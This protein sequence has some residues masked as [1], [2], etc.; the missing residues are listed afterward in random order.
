M[1][2]GRQV[3]TFDPIAQPSGSFNNQ[4]PRGC[5]IIRIKNDSIVDLI[6]SINNFASL[7]TEVAP[8]A[9]V[10]IEGEVPYTQ[11]YWSTQYKLTTNVKT[12]AS[13]VTVIVYDPGET[14]PDIT[15]GLPRHFNPTNVG[16]ETGGGISMP[17]LAIASIAVFNP[18]GSGVNATF[19][20]CIYVG[21]NISPSQPNLSFVTS[22]PSLSTLTITND[23]LG[24]PASACHASSSGNTF[25]HGTGM[26]SYVCGGN[27]QEL[28]A[29]PRQIVAPPGFGLAVNVG[30]NVSTTQTIS[31]DFYWTETPI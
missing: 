25:N 28:I 2:R 30:S 23:T 1:A 11:I 15:A 26:T 12:I 16:F 29:F 31:V 20:S 27:A 17:A 10:D 5:G 8:G 19:I 21:L 18:P 13:T 7:A 22:D 14:P 3:I 6:F 24:G 9:T 4:L